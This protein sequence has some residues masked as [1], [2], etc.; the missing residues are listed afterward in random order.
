MARRIGTCVYCGSEGEL[1]RDHIPPKALCGK[2]RP[3]DLVLVPSCRRCNEGASKDDEYFKT[4]LVLK[5][6]SGSHPEAEA[7]RDSVLR[8]L[9]LPAKAPFAK[10]LLDAMEDVDLKTAAGLVVGRATALNVDLLRLDRVAERVARGLYWHHHG[11]VPLPAHYRVGVWSEAGL[12]N[13]DART[14]AEL[15]DTLLAPV[16]RN[17]ARTIGRGALRYWCASG[18][19]A[20]LTC[21]LLEFFGDV[22]FIAVTV[23]P[24]VQLGAQ[25]PLA[26]VG[27]PR[28]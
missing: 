7:I 17:P 24:D 15:Q 5:D 1:T 6:K 16:L 28:R 22:R 19:R 18:D 10:R 21:W 2:P 9:A 13:L 26:A 4:T 11:H 3:D 8:A 14:A 27:G 12:R 25:Q 23:P 20:H